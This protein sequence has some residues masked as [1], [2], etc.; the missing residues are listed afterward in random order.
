MDSADFMSAFLEELDEQLVRMEQQI[1]ELEQHGDDD[2]TIQTLFRVAHTLKGSCAAMGFEDMKNLTHGI[3]QV[4][5]EV[6]N[7]RL[8]VSE[9]MIQLLFQCF[10]GLQHFKESIVS[11][12]TAVIPID[13]LLRALQV[14]LHGPAKHSQ[15]HAEVMSTTVVLTPES[16]IM[17]KENQQ[18]G[19]L[20]YDVYFRFHAHS[21][22]RGVRAYLSVDALKETGEVIQVS[23]SLEVIEHME[24]TSIDGFHAVLA[25]HLQ[26]EQIQS[27]VTSEE[28]AEVLCSELAHALAP[29]E[30]VERND[31]QA[32]STTTVRKSHSVRVDVEQLETLMNLVG[33][34]VIDQARMEQVSR[35]LTK[36]YATDDA[37]TT[38]GDISA[39]VSRIVSALQENIMMARMLPIESLFERFPRIVRDLAHT[40]GKDVQLSL[41]G[42]ETRMDRTVI[43]EIADP[44]IHLIRNAVDHGIESEERRIQAGKPKKGHLT[45]AASHE[46]NKVVITIQD[47]GAGMDAEQIRQAAI[48]KG[49]ITAEE[50]EKLKDNECLHLIFR[51]GFSTAERVSDISGRGVGMDIVRSHIERLSGTIEIETQIK[52]GTIFRIKLPLTLA[53]IPG[54]LIGIADRTFVVPVSNVFEIVR[55]H[56]SSIQSV[57]GKPTLLLRGLATPVVY[58]R[59]YFGL[60][61]NR[62]QRKQLPVVVVGTGEKRV[63]MVVD[64]LYGNQDIVKKSLSDRVGAPEGISG[65]T[66]LGDGNVGLILD[67]TA[68]SQGLEH[69]LRA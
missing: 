27:A 1:V 9:E 23:P 2:E 30:S 3:E 65:A 57:H 53:I 32:P 10:D 48:A 46:D 18:R 24:D 45:L 17:L 15:S 26:S 20:V 55:I 31:K 29:E 38:L 66:I 41:E 68:I 43:E 11:G 34:L 33:E 5:D 14:F 60:P 25:T 39:H 51:P 54:L 7:H 63:A 28:Y 21:V 64:V 62:D 49:V 13:G 8:F 61:A 47:D 36:K 12:D 6:R 67:I 44:L 42:K 69:K 50:A 35:H 52:Q 40:L 19:L 4:L 37:V 58:L 16:Q 22:M 56:P 59:E